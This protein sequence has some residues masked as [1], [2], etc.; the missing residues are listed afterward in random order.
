MLP[1]L[2][3]LQVG[4]VH[5]P[6]ASKA[7]RSL[8][9]KDVKFPGALKG[10]LSNL[11]LKA[12]VQ[13]IYAELGTGLVDALVFMG[14]LTD[15]GD[16]GGFQSCAEYLITA[17]E[18]GPGGRFEKLPTGFVPG[19]HDVDRQLAVAKGMEAKFKP[20]ADAMEKAGATK[21]ATTASVSF[22]VARDSASAKIHLLNSCWGCGEPENIPVEFRDA[23]KTAIDAVIAKDAKSVSVYYDRQLD[24]PAFDSDTIREI[25]EA[26]SEGPATCL[27]VLVAHHNLLPQRTP[28]L[29]PYTELVNSGALRGAL[30]G[31]ERPCIY[32][33]G[34]IHEDPVEIVKAGDGPPLVLV[35]APEAAAG[36][37][38]IE[39]VFM[40]SGLPLACE[41]I[42]Y[43][44]VAGSVKRGAGQ[45][46]PLM[47]GRRRSTDRRLANVYAHLLQERECFWNDLLNFAETFGE[48]VTEDDLAEIIELLNAD[49]S[50][51][52][53]NR[54]LPP[55]NWIVRADL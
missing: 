5:Y 46:I 31:S 53:E 23:I 30:I 48:P 37:N 4:D 34:H 10:A 6:S 1:R 52:I 42:P 33:H 9:D 19:N 54:D 16:L 40:R 7:D 36:F 27:S 22:D 26:V 47:G 25:S 3:I 13:R 15:Q 32:L 55:S 14:D 11:P 45:A 35:S 38:V 8:D 21:F 20:L 49:G 12:V 44:Y 51:R 24:T 2:R 29:A 43:R 50:V 17:L 18:L 41:I 39:I 28:R